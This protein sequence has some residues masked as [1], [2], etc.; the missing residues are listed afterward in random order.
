MMKD[1]KNDNVR[2]QIRNMKPDEVN[3]LWECAH[4]PE[5]RAKTLAAQAAAKPVN[6]PAY[7][8]VKIDMDHIK[9]GHTE[10]GDRVSPRKDLF[11]KDMSDKAIEGAVR[12]AYKNGAKLATQGERVLVEGKSGSLT[13]QMW[14]N[15]ATKT[16]E[17]AW[18][19]Y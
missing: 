17:A 7:K 5:C 2:N 6:L 10:G 14:V 15:K 9:S 18:P 8:D 19:K 3:N 4:N 13:I 12:E 1:V 16:I 11:P